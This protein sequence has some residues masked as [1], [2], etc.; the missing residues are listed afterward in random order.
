VSKRVGLVGLVGVVLILLITWGAWGQWHSIEEPSPVEITYMRTCSEIVE[1]LNT[2]EA[3][4]WSASFSSQSERVYCVVKLDIP[5][6]ASLNK[7]WATMQW[8]T[9]NGDPYE[10]QKWDNLRRGKTWSLYGAID[11]RGTEAADLPGQWRVTFS[12]R[13]GPRKTVGFSIQR[14]LT[15]G[16]GVSLPGPGV[17]EPVTGRE[18]EP[19]D[20]AGTANLL[21]FDEKVQGEV[22]FYSED[23]YDQD[24]YRIELAGDEE[25]W[26]EVNAVGMT[27][28][29]LSPFGFLGVYQ[30]AALVPMSLSWDAQQEV[31]EDRSLCDAVV[32]IQGP[33]TYYVFIQAKDC[34]HD[35]YYSLQIATSK[36]EVAEGES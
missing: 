22:L 11:V 21:A 3:R 4:A 24:W 18:Q 2:F 25:Y 28:Q 20:A 1:R 12:V 17:G 16:E 8:Y 19:N 15:T 9:P 34:E 36:P 23:V 13:R 6:D 29:W 26:L 5:S 35:I 7:Y 30:G 33:G 31:S 14:A 32:P 27:S 10:Q